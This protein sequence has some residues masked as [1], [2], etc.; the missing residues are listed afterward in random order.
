MTEENRMLSDP[1]KEMCLM[2]IL[3]FLVFFVGGAVIAASQGEYTGLRI[4]GK[5]LYLGGGTF[6]MLY[7]AAACA[8]AFSAV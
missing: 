4:I 2:E 7:L 5:V 6:L 8:G 3:L 1:G